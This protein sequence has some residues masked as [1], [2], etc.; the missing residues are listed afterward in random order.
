[1]SKKKGKKEYP[2]T[3]KKK[4]SSDDLEKL[5]KIQMLDNMEYSE[6]ILE[7]QGKVEFKI[8]KPR[9]IGRKQKIKSVEQ[10][11]ELIDEQREM[12]EQ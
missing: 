12:L 6:E 3:L 2:S 10:T 1:M 11:Q 5:N 7:N 4:Y 9:R 8:K